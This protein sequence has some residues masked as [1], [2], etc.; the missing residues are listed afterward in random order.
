MHILACLRI[1]AVGGAALGLESA[2]RA[3]RLSVSYLLVAILISNLGRS[4]IPPIGGFVHLLL[5]LFRHHLESLIKHHRLNDLI[6]ICVAQLICVE[7]PELFDV[8]YQL[9]MR[10][11][12][13]LAC[14]SLNSLADRLDPCEVELISAR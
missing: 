3:R 12:S 14:T 10:Y 8:D 1:D 6:D 13:L 4:G 2:V 11:A 9:S 5:I 7:L